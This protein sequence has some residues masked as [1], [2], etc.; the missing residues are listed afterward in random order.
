[1][2]CSEYILYLPEQKRDATFPHL[3]HCA[4]WPPSHVSS[5]VYINRY[6]KEIYTW[7][8]TTK[9]MKTQ[10]SLPVDGN[11]T[12]RSERTKVDVNPVHRYHWPHIST[13]STGS[14]QRL[15][16]WLSQRSYYEVPVSPG[17]GIRLLK[18]TEFCS[19]TS[20]GKMW[21]IRHY[22]PGSGVI[23]YSGIMII[24]HTWAR[25]HKVHYVYASKRPYDFTFSRLK[26]KW[27]Q[28]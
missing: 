7:T 24:T 23:I 28:Q 25:V 13:P 1:M 4:N 11:G 2:S 18:W 6:S 17:A 15:S 3:S 27:N 9:T 14:W 20:I 8:V 26:G 21:Y 22:I 19:L 16:M 5:M 12:K 10:G